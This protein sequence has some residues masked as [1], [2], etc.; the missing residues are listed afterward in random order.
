VPDLNDIQHD[1]A[2]SRFYLQGESGTAFI[3][4][5]RDNGAML[6][7]HTE[8]PPEM[9]GGGIG[10]MLVRAAL[11]YARSLGLRIVPLCPFVAAW[12]RRHP[13][14]GKD[15]QQPGS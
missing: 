13:E 4:Y 11:D 2:G 12:I 5:R 15:V 6:F 7:L 1:E 3:N 14:Y 10:S 8:V 9:K